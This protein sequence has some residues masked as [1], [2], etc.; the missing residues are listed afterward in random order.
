[1]E[2][3]GFYDQFNLDE[4]WDS[5]TNLLAASLRPSIYGCP[6][7]RSNIDETNYV[8]IVGRNTASPGERG[9]TIDEFVDGTSETIML[10]EV[11]DSG[12]SWSEPRDLNANEISFGINEGTD[13]ISSVHN[14]LAN[15]ALVDGS[16]HY[17]H[18]STN[19]ETI[20]QMTTVAGGEAVVVPD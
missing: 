3:P 14:G 4:P 12:I 9:R 19:P 16:V 1:M 20:R 2:D 10:V 11:T 15:V 6:S 7:N 8:M 17:F 13:G 18:D 5:P